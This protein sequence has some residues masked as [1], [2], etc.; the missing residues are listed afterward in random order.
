RAQ[1]KRFEEES[2]LT[3]YL[4]KATFD[5]VVNLVE[6]PTTLVA[7]FD[8]EFLE[9]P[10]EIVIDTLLTHQRYFPVYDG[11]RHL[12]NKFLVVSNASPAY[13]SDVI[14]GHERVV[15][16]RLAD[17]V[18]FYREDLKTPLAER[19]EQLGQVVFHERLGSLR[20]KTERLVALATDI[21]QAVQEVDADVGVEQVERALRAA[22]LAKADLVTH[23]VV[24]FTA[25]QGIM[26][27]YYALAAGEPVEVANAIRE[28]YHP[29]YA[30]DEL[31]TSF[32]G[33]V[34]AVADKLD[35]IAGLFA[36]GQQPTGSSDPFALRRSAIGIINILLAGFPISLVSMIDAALSHL[37]GVEFDF[38]TVAAE[39][40]EFF[41]GRLEVIAKERG[42][43]VDIVSAVLAANAIEP[44]EIM[45]KAEA[46]SAAREQN[47]ELLEDLAT[48]YARA[49]NLRDAALGTDI[50]QE[51]LEDSEVALL[52]AIDK[53]GEGVGDSVLAKRYDRAVQYLA[54]LRLPI[55]RFFEEVLVMDP[56]EGR[57]QN[58]LRLLNRFVAV[59]A[60]VADI[61]KLVKP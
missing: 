11:E 49:N 55:D 51:L 52:K 5:E 38:A 59:F 30:S 3:A 10:P 9:V 53:V 8:E 33:S 44:L 26:G 31:P 40:R 21:T 14:A 61:S 28:H 47:P 16:P 50:D 18:F 39:I 60:Q 23:A 1:V 41:A 27:D 56:D 2:G 20:D 58:R 34:V 45:A 35:T 13:N 43:G 36:I 57:R 7:S 32:E 24:E 29:R 22:L 48:A 42:I 54:S 4:P 19:V 46:L 37:E 12:T 6:F 15:R 17:A 25:L